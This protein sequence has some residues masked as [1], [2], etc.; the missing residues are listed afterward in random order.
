M[1]P[2]LGLAR[3]TAQNTRGVAKNW[4]RI[5]CDMI[6][7]WLRGTPNYLHFRGHFTYALP[8]TEYVLTSKEALKGPLRTVSKSAEDCTEAVLVN[9]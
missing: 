7:D 2:T 3:G 1:P 5:L 9:C 8:L 6:Y 4:L